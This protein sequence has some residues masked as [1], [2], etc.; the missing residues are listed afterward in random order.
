MTKA[1]F[2]TNDAAVTGRA[3]EVPA[4]S[5]LNGMN[6]GASNAPAIGI[7]VGVTNIVGT[8]EQFTLLDQAGVARTPQLSQIIGAAATPVSVATV[9]ATG[10]GTATDDGDATLVSLAAGWTAV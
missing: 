4:A 1:T 3:I 5:F 10:D 8:D 6:L 2:Y 7:N 9:S